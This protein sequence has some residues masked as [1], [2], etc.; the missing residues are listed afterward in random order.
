MLFV[1]TEAD[2]RAFHAQNVL[3]NYQQGRNGK[4]QQNSFVAIG[5]H[6]K[7][8]QTSILLEVPIWKIIYWGEMNT[9]RN[10]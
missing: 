8:S 9:I 10:K 1:Y 3:V 2:S 6:I 5:W 7:Y 4:G